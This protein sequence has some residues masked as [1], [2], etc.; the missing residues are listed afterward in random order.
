[1]LKKLN[2]YNDSTT[3]AISTISLLVIEAFAGIQ[4]PM[5]ILALEEDFRGICVQSDCPQ[6]LKQSI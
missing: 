3:L 6:L 1:M 2:L 4:E 5:S